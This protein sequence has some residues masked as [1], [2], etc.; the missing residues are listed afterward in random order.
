MDPLLGPT[1]AAATEDLA[2]AALLTLP[3]WQNRPP[4]S[5]YGRRC[6]CCYSCGCLSL[7]CCS[8]CEVVNVSILD[9]SAPAVALW[10]WPVLSR[11]FYKDNT[12][13]AAVVNWAMNCP[14][15]G[16]WMDLSTRSLLSYLFWVL[17]QQKSDFSCCSF[18]FLLRAL[19][20]PN[21][22]PL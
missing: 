22:S 12:D 17:W 6:Y 14:E 11:V 15:Y 20:V 8:I 16:V 18:V 7:C 21:C 19:E 9:P 2:I 13:A 5:V 10:I 3:L 4:V 1:D